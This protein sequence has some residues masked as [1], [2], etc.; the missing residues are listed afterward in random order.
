ME[1]GR[2]REKESERERKNATDSDVRVVID[3]FAQ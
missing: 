2:E 1:G 3:D